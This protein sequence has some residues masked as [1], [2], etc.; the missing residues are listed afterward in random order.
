MNNELDEKERF[1]FSREEADNPYIWQTT[2]NEP[3]KEGLFKSFPLFVQYLKRVRTEEMKEGERLIL[4]KQGMTWPQAR[5]ETIITTIR[6]LRIHSYP[7]TLLVG[8]DGKILSLNNRRK[9]QPELRGKELL[10]SLDELL[11][12]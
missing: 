2:V 1:P 5:R 10:K 11:P 12:P 4:E 3:L 9:D 7:T 8:P 6:N